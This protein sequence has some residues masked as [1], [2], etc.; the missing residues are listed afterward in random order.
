MG[1]ALLTALVILSVLTVT[2]CPNES[3]DGNIINI[4]DGRDLKSPVLLSVSTDSPRVVRLSFNEPVLTQRFS[5]DGFETLSDDCDVLVFL[6]DALKP[7]HFRYISGRVSDV[8]GNTSS[9]SVKVWGHNS[10]PAGL[11]INEFTTS[12]SGK[13]PD[14]TELLVTSDGSLCGLTVYDGVPENFR[15]SVMLDDIKVREGSFVVIFWTDS[16]PEGTVSHPSADIYNICAGCQ[17]SGLSENNGII[18]VTVSPAEGARVLDCL[19]Y[20]TQ[21]STQYDG[22]GTKE[23]QMRIQ[24]ALRD[25]YLKQDIIS[26]KGSTATRSVSRSSDGSWYI[27]Q[28]GGCTFGS[29]NR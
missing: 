3:P 29:P 8:S 28:T 2:S 26:P 16:L 10:S 11:M 25:G 12:G 27:T 18:T 19:A 4:S 9:V 7:G 1:K 6:D 21:E 17:S 14:R 15:N 20:S 5:F 13:N 23:V 24:S 22:F